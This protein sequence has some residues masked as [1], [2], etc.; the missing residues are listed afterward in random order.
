MGFVDGKLT[1]PATE[2]EQLNEWIRC[3][4]RVK[5]WLK[6]SMEKEVRSSV[7]FA[8]TAREILIDLGERSPRL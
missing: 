5:G 3:D 8:R 1:K 2:A 7:R 4:S 6:T